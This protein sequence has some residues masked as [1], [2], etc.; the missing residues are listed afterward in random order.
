MHATRFA[1]AVIFLLPVVVFSRFRSMPLKSSITSVQPMT[2]I[3]LWTDSD[4]NT[5]DAV[6]LEF[7]YMLY[8]E[9]VKEQGKYDWSA[10]DALLQSVAA[11][12]H[13]A[14]LRFRFVYPGYA[15]S[16]PDYIKQL[17]DYHETEG[18]SEGL[19]TF[20]P[21][22]TNAEL[23][24]F[25]LDFYSRFAE[26]YDD[27]PRL[28]F[29][30]TGF[31]LWAEYHIYD[32]PFELGKTF[33]S[34][35]FQAAFFRHLDTVFVTTPW[36]ISVDAADDTYSP[37]EQQ[38][39]LK[40]IEFGLFDDSFMHEEHDGYNTDC[41]NFFN[42][43]RFLRSPAGGEFSYYTDFDQRHVLDRAGIHGT[44]WEE[45]SAAF[46]I[47]YMIGNDQP[48][49]Q[50]MDRIREAGMASGYRF[51]IN[52]FAASADSSIVEVENTGMAPLYFDAY[53]A[54][55]GVRANESLKYLAPES[56][57]TCRIPA[58]GDNPPLTI[59]CDRLVPGQTIGYEADLTGGSGV[60][61][62]GV[63]GRQRYDLRGTVASM[64]LFSPDGRSVGSWGNI[65]SRNELMGVRQWPHG[66][67][68]TPGI[69]ICRIGKGGGNPSIRRLVVQ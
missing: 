23:Q 39:E 20:F 56:T 36:S 62:G 6:S 29:L 58:G 18:E 65:S 31:G 64:E 5:T 22:W 26:Q 8:N 47:S 2:G 43:N 14:I 11:R 57:L 9:V 44:T 28:A 30:Q 35:Q 25:T 24:R 46:H 41:W 38:N 37:F 48:E 1:A 60:A 53:V 21:D 54:V 67:M 16:V 59:E 17:S 61:G 4:G 32:G 52:S 19:T 12:K 63:R 66:C 68:I 7:S 42:R 13:Q 69:Y 51:R 34:K 10:V 45:A 50:T 55:G 40:A 15:T 27:D 33:P 49:Y 3:V